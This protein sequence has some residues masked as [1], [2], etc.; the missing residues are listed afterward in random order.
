MQLKKKIKETSDN[1]QLTPL[2]KE[3]Q[4]LDD[5]E[6]NELETIEE[7]NSNGNGKIL[8]V[9]KKIIYVLKVMKNRNITHKQL[10]HFVAEYEIMN[11]LDH[12][13]ILK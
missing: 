3:F 10:Q 1:S 13:N 2:N 9:A 12:P 7:I 11:A 4:I 8:K 6:I 5:D